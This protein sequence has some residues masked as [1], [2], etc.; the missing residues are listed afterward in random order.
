MGLSAT[1]MSHFPSYPIAYF[2][3]EQTV[4]T[5]KSVDQIIGYRRKLDFLI[6]S[7]LTF[8]LEA[9]EGLQT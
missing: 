2:A 7:R 8:S 5:V 6:F 1:S 3:Y 9:F 4:N